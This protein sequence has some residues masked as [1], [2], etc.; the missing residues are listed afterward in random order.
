MALDKKVIVCIKHRTSAHQPS[1][2]AKGSEALAKQIE[3]MI[4]AKGLMLSVERFK[5]LGC[6]DQGINIKLVPE[7][8]FLH[9]LTLEN[10]DE[11]AI[12][13]ENF[14]NPAH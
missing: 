2:A 13:L 6:C 4:I 11:L 12:A 9:G 10:L 14:A 8:P 1:C 7:G 5:C 3:Q